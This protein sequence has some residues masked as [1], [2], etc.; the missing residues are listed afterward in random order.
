MAG[1]LN[2]ALDE[3]L[4]ERAA[5]AGELQLRFFRWDSP[6]V[7]IG[8]TVAMEVGKAAVVLFGGADL[9]RRPTGGGV[10]YHGEQMSFSLAWPRRGFRMPGGVKE[11]CCCIHRAVREALNECGI[12]CHQAECG[13][14][15]ATLMCHSTIM[16]G[17]VLS[18]AGT[19]LAGG[20]LWL[21]RGAVLYQGHLWLRALPVLE[22][23][24]T[25]RL[26]EC[27]GVSARP[28]SPAAEE[29][30]SAG[31]RCGSWCLAEA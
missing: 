26:A 2:M 19:K 10:V 23:A 28:D 12:P 14:S 27:L 22:E 13:G 15:R 29:L 6:T 24:L 17:D 16:A 21:A 18:Q 4:T 25:G 8:R 20:A 1:A 9:V 3:V 5:R 30:E 7:S 11:A 31:L